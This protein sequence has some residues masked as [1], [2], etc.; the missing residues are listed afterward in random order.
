MIVIYKYHRRMKSKFTC[1]STSK[2]YDTFSLYLTYFLKNIFNIVKII[3]TNS[4]T[5][6]VLLLITFHYNI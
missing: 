2:E 6:Q 4:K 1:R 5:R 3:T